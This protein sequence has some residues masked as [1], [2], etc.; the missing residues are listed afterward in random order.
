MTMK[1]LLTS[2]LIFVFIMSTALF[3]ACTEVQNYKYYVFIGESQA[4]EITR[5]QFFVIEG[6]TPNDPFGV[7]D[8]GQPRMY[9]ELPVDSV[10][11]LE[12]VVAPG[13]V[14][15]VTITSVAT[16]GEQHPTRTLRGSRT[17]AY[18]AQNRQ[19]A[20]LH[21]VTGDT[22]FTIRALV[23]V[24]IGDTAP[25]PMAVLIS[26]DNSVIVRQSTSPLVANVFPENARPNTIVWS[27]V[28][29]NIATVDPT[30]GV[31][32]GVSDGVATI[33]ATVYGTA[34][35]STHQVTVSLSDQTRIW[36]YHQG[37]TN[38][39]PHTPNL[40]WWEIDGT[41]ESQ[42]PGIA[43]TR[44]GSTNWFFV[45]IDH[46]STFSPIR[47]IVSIPGHQTFDGVNAPQI[48]TESAYF[49]ISWNNG[50]ALVTTTR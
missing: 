3:T 19:F 50:Y 36:F 20:A 32:T 25:A 22:A 6:E 37:W 39:N 35:T 45:D 48:N 9:A 13:F 4:T 47:I 40:H 1:K 43:M 30:T 14:G 16:D 23:E 31:V 5:F 8:G 24:P 26:G 46:N 15:E 18:T 12:W 29:P 10:V 21:T 7:I 34:V 41:A 44:D 42:W 33:R 11:I 38:W 17:V 27:S 2:A 28:T 49:Q